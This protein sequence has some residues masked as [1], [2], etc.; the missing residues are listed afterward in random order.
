MPAALPPV[1]VWFNK[2]FSS[3]HGVLRQLRGDW[4]PGL[5]LIGTHTERDFGPLASCDTSAVEPLGLTSEEYVAWCLAFCAANAVD[6]FIPGRMRESIAD[7]RAD[8]EAAGVKLIVAGDGD[9]LR[10]LEDKGRFL[11][12]VPEGVAV[13]RFYRVRNWAEFAGACARIEQEG[14]PVCFK[15]AVSTFGLG[16]YILDETMTPLRRLLRSE[17]HRITKAELKSILTASDSFPE[18]L[19]MEYLD[20]SEFSVDVLAH[21]GGV[22]SMVCRRKPIN[23]R[24]RLTGTS[25]T[26]RVEEG[27]SQSLAREPAIEE[28]VRRLA[29]HFHLGGLFNVQFRSRAE[30]PERPCLLEINGR[31][32]GGMPYI[33]L[34]G[35]NL[36]LWAIRIALTP[37][38]EPFPEIPEP[39]L[40][41]RV[42]ER[43]EVFIMPPN[44]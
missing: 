10:L 30:R 21:A 44:A 1:R 14:L 9:T 13:H 17:A 25:R 26:I 15:P 8:F 2:C 43:S 20:G 23:G 22:L 41:L 4:G 16:F 7:R 5:T 27:L 28:M 33:R 6:V 34:T 3:I 40:P 24:V 42:Q 32:A 37:A 38:G 12:A 39:H 11:A 19:V 18:L 35:L 29:R 31:M 36:P